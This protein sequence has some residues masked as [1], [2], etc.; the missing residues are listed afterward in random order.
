MDKKVD[1]ASDLSVMTSN[2]DAEVGDVLRAI[3]RQKKKTEVEII[4]V[5]ATAAENAVQSPVAAT[6]PARTSSKPRMRPLFVAEDEVI[7][8]NV[9]TRLRRETNAILTEAAL[10]Q[11]LKKINPATRQDIV[12]VALREWFKKH[13]YAT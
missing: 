12:E 11:R 2:V 1:F 5:A 13:G 10:R 6:P 3:S 8:E 4:D 9:T 7:L